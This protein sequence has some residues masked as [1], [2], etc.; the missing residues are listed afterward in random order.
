MAAEI[1]AHN[2]RASKVWGSGGA[3]YE[4]VSRGILD[5]IEHSVTRLAPQAG[6]RVLDVA[7]GT[8]WTARRVATRGAQVVGVDIA[9]DLL[10]AARGFARAAGLD[11]E[12]RLADAERLPFS[13]GEFDAAISTCGVMFVGKPEAAAAELARVVRPGGRLALTT[14]LNDGNLFKMFQVMKPYMAPPPSPAPASPF[15]WGKTERLRELLGKAFDL[16]FEKAISYYREPGGEGAW[17]TFSTGYGPVKSL[18][19]SL[20]EARQAE[21][22]RDFIRFHDGFPS[23]IGICVPREYCMTLGVRR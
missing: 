16:K 4:E 11:I 15:E 8:G 9:A 22:R 1:Q 7:T 3:A 18:M 20:D 6:E 12:F 19:A 23:E 14:W 17:N 5:S 2:E 21:L 10:D 13:D